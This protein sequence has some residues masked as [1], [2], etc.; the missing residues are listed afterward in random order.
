MSTLAIGTAT[1]M[2]ASLLGIAQDL[3]EDVREAGEDQSLLEYAAGRATRRL[4]VSLGTKNPDAEIL[5]NLARR[6]NMEGAHELSSLI[7]EVGL[8]M[9]G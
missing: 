1:G 6:A 4:R 2:Q 5:N 7:D 3:M 8:A 9:T